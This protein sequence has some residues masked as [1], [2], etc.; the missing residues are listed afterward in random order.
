M[1]FQQFW[2]WLTSQLTD[3]VAA[4]T[5]AVAGAIEPAVVTLATIYVMV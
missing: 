3:Y 1:F 2:T 5:A 4:K